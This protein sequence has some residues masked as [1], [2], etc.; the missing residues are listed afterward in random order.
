M[1]AED[2]NIVESPAWS[3]TTGDRIALHRLRNESTTYTIYNPGIL[4]A[5]ISSTVRRPTHLG[6][7]IKTGGGGI[8]NWVGYACRPGERWKTTPVDIAYDYTAGSYPILDN[9][10]WEF[11]GA[12]FSINPE[13]LVEY[14]EYIDEFTEETI[15]TS[16][17]TPELMD[18]FTDPWGYFLRSKPNRW[19]G[20]TAWWTGVIPISAAEELSSPDDK[21][22]SGL[23][24][25]R[26]NISSPAFDLYPF[27]YMFS[28]QFEGALFTGYDAGTSSWSYTDGEGPYL[29]VRDS[30]AGDE[31][32][33]IIHTV[34]KWNTE[35]TYTDQDN[36]GQFIPFTGA[37]I[38][39][40]LSV[41]L[42]ETG[43]AP[44]VRVMSWPWVR[45]AGIRAAK[46]KQ[47][48]LTSGKI[49]WRRALPPR[50]IGQRSTQ[51]DR[52]SDGPLEFFVWWVVKAT[53]WDD[54][55]EWEELCTFTLATDPDDPYADPN[56][57]RT[58]PENQLVTF[59]TQPEPGELVF[60]KVQH[61]I[62]TYAQDDFYPYVPEINLIL[63]TDPIQLPINVRS[64]SGI[65]PGLGRASWPD[66]R[67]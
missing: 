67:V 28:T 24:V 59:T 7:P 64:K 16:T 12:V 38:P 31:G 20:L 2:F 39:L 48:D 1:S 17:P 47:E 19:D 57:K 22:V 61:D 35:L 37:N 33:S 34:P 4:S 50:L 21:E 55:S 15:Y 8:D 60:L 41:H 29:Y 26:L 25:D 42:I 46:I 43:Y 9:Y 54:D 3:N 14:G 40:D 63:H 11:R 36:D 56:V 52:L 6:G 44:L 10:L 18:F 5:F 53:E 45:S 66:P 32:S 62:V 58:D 23:R 51:S 65:V 13:N 30:F 49:M 27:E